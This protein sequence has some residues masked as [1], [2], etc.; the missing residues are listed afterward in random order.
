M[1]EQELVR[2]AAGGDTEAFARLVRTYENKIY[3]LAF[4]MCGS[5]DDAGDIAQE[6]FL[7]LIHI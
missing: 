7:S 3:S 1:T 6:A 2:A 5:A 4:R